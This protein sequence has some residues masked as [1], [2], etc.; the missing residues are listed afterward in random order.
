MF[1][2]SSFRASAQIADP[3]DDDANDAY[4]SH[5]VSDD[6]SV[7][8]GVAP[9]IGDGTAHRG[10]TSSSLDVHTFLDQFNSLAGEYK[11]SKRNLIEKD[12]RIE[13]LEAKL[14]NTEVVRS[15]LQ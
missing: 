11:S 2:A 9:E 15:L 12:K 14:S 1:R 6:A 5:V 3:A 4:D 10:S 8:V 7:S 13:E